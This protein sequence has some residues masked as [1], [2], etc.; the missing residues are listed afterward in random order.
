[1]QGGA[2][3]LLLTLPNGRVLNA[4]AHYVNDMRGNAKFPRMGS[5]AFRNLTRRVVRTLLERRPCILS[6]GL[7][8]PITFDELNDPDH[9]L[10]THMFRHAFARYWVKEEED[11]HTASKYLDHSD[12][13]MILEVYL[14]ED[15]SDLNPAAKMA[16]LP[17][18]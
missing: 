15:E 18:G 17:G 8:E 14:G 10:A 2:R 7:D 13:K 12:H 4:T 16:H 11:L 3:V 9:V 1:M 5:D 6:P